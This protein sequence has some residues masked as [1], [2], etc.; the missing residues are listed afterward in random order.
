P[1]G[2]RPPGLDFPGAAGQALPVCARWTPLL[3]VAVAALTAGCHVSA[4]VG[5]GC[6]GMIDS[7]K[8]ERT[9]RTLIAQQT[10]ASVKSVSCPRNIAERKGATFTCTLTGADGTTA[11]ALVTQ[12]DDKGNV[13]I[14]APTLLHTGA[15]AR[16]IAQRLTSQFAF[17]V[18]VRCPDLVNAHRGTKLTCTATDPKGARR[19]V[20][21]TV[22]DD[23]GS[24]DYHLG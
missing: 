23:H 9:T 11:T 22:T 20:A 2:V 14:S 24:I 12:K 16:L 19:P 15:A 13:E 7:A 3:A 8:A 1:P 18:T 21:V 10:G 17:T 4:C 5:S 6:A